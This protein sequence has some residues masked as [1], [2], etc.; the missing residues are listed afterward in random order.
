[1]AGPNPADIFPTSYASGMVLCNKIDIAT[2]D[3]TQLDKEDGEKLLLYVSTSVV[4]AL[5]VISGVLQQE[6]P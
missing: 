3:L 4:K 1:M 2:P 6:N 5:H